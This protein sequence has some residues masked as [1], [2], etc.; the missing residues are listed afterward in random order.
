MSDIHKTFSSFIHENRDGVPSRSQS[1]SQRSCHRDERRDASNWLVHLLAGRADARGA[2]DRRLQNAAAKIKP[3]LFAAR[4]RSAS[5]RCRTTQKGNDS[6][7]Q[8]KKC[9]AVR[10]RMSETLVR[11]PTG[12]LDRSRTYT[13]R[14]CRRVSGVVA[15]S[16]AATYG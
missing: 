5:R 13:R 9:P 15:A 8:R 6:T 16:P 7:R 4:T 11:A 10:R 14:R 2:R 1:M 3:L 12:C